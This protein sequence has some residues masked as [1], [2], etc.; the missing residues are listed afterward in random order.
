M[1]DESSLQIFTKRNTGSVTR[2]VSQT[3]KSSSSRCSELYFLDIVSIFEF[4]QEF[5]YTIGCNFEVAVREKVKASHEKQ[6]SAPQIDP[7]SLSTF[8]ITVD[9]QEQE[10]RDA[11]RLPYEKCVPSIII[12]SCLVN[13]H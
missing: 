2:K 13:S 11:L 5:A 1:K 10:S 6:S 4:V 7:E 3:K 8:R 12:C 9:E